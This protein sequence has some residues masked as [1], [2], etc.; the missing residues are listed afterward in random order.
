MNNEDILEQCMDLANKINLY[1]RQRQKTLAIA[2]SCTGGLL[3]HIITEIPKAS[4]YFLISV[5]SYSILSKIKCLNINADIL[6]IYGAVSKETSEEMAI[7]VRRLAGSDFSISTTGNLGPSALD[8]KPVGLAYISVC[9]EKDLLTRELTL[10]GDR[11]RNKVE[12]VLNAL[13][14]FN[15]VA[16][17]R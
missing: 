2:E 10:T 7:S 1:L 6:N 11:H 17:E 13:R 12:A 9:L 8:D 4:D 3:S 16:I 15:E 5:V 14:F